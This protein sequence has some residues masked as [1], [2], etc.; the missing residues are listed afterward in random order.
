VATPE[1]ILFR[2]PFDQEDRRA[3]WVVEV[4]I[5]ER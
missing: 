3:T 2:T 1:K 5:P 4:P